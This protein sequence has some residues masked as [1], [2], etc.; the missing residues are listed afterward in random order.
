MLR[1]LLKLI[2]NGLKLPAWYTPHTYT[3]T[4]KKIGANKHTIGMRTGFQI[5]RWGKGEMANG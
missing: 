5:L 3:D 1:M 2:G 4:H